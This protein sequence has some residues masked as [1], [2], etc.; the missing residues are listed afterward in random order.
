MPNSRDKCQRKQKSNNETDN[1][2]VPNMKE[3]L[4]TEAKPNQKIIITTSCPPPNP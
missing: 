1:N 3:Q 4:T 2:L